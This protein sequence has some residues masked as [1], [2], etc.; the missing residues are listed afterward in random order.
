MQMPELKFENGLVTYNLN[1]ACEVSF[2]P[3]DSAFVE[4]KQTACFKSAA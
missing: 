2:N 3:T 1:G 4:R